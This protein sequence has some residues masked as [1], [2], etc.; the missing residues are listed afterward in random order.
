MGDPVEAEHGNPD[1]CDT[2]QLTTTGLAYWRCAS[3]LLTFAAF[4]DGQ[5]HWAWVAQGLME[6]TGDADPPDTAP[7]IRASTSD[8]PDDHRAMT[9]LAVGRS[10]SSPDVPVPGSSPR[11]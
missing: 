11:P 2:E 6:W 9:C 3:N 5:N 1:N 8:N 4:P 10:P 7:V